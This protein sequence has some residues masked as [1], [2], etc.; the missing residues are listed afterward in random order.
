MTVAPGNGQF[1]ALVSASE[2]AGLASG[3][4]VSASS[5]PAIPDRIETLRRIRDGKR[6]ELDRHRKNRNAEWIAKY[7]LEVRTLDWAARFIEEK[8]RNGE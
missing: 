3:S 5:A 2:R 8:T 6:L 1:T 7:D 4:A